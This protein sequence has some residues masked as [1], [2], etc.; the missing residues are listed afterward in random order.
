MDI[1]VGKERKECLRCCVN[2]Y[3]WNSIEIVYTDNS[4][5]QCIIVISN[6]NKIYI[7]REYER[8]T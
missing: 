6:G 1:L 3:L 8:N 2:I 4:T 5:Y 7:E